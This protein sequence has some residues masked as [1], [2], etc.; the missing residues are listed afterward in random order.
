MPSLSHLFNVNLEVQCEIPR[1]WDIRVVK[2]HQSIPFADKN[3]KKFWGAANGERKPVPH[4]I[5]RLEAH[6]YGA[7]DVSLSWV[8]E[9]ATLFLECGTGMKSCCCVC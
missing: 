4:H 6:A 7:L 3:F 2:L 9:V 8:L 5:P 1:Q